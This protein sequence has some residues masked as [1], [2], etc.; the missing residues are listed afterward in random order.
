LALDVLS[1]FQKT[2]FNTKALLS[3]SKTVSVLA[4]C[5]AKKT[6]LV[7]DTPNTATIFW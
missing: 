6:L 1:E 2:L 4:I 5:L 7:S 3:N